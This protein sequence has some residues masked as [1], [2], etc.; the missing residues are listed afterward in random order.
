MNENISYKLEELY[1]YEDELSEEAFDIF[2]K[3][4]IMNLLDTYYYHAGIDYIENELENIS[5]ILP[6]DKFTTLLANTVYQYRSIKNRWLN[7]KIDQLYPLYML[8]FEGFKPQKKGFHETIRSILLKLDIDNS[9]YWFKGIF[10]EFYSKNKDLIISLHVGYRNAINIFRN[11]TICDFTFKYRDSP[12]SIKPG[13]IQP[14]KDIY[15]INDI[16][17]MR[18][19]ELEPVLFFVSGRGDISF[20]EHH[21]PI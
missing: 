2:S 15:H 12:H 7:I 19:N 20:W 21:L 17:K 11:M 5:F 9:Y 14:G 10:P 8:P 18:N 13:I 3:C 16:I 4:Y 1:K 6:D